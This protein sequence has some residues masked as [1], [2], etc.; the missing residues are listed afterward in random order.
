M[1]RF[2][3]VPLVSAHHVLMC[4]GAV[5]VMSLCLGSVGA[6][7][8]CEVLLFVKIGN[9]SN[10]FRI[11]FL[12]PSFSPSPSGISIICVLG[13][14]KLTHSFLRLWS[15]DVTFSLARSGSRV[16]FTLC[17]SGPPTVAP[18]G[19]KCAS[20]LIFHVSTST[21]EHISNNNCFT[22]ILS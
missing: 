8:I 2:F 20:F 16:L 22:V 11:F 4:F 7:R 9:S 12:F 5:L 19:N 15:G 3:S 13:H 1:G 14:L 21:S 17:A 18:T 6:S 10:I